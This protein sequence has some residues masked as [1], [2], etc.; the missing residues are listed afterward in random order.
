MPNLVGLTSQDQA[1]AALVDAS[2][3]LGKVTQVDS[4]QPAGAVIAQSVPAATLVDAGT[5]ID[6]SVSNGQVKV[7]DVTGESE[8]QARSDLTNAGF[9]P[10][11][12]KQ[13]D[14]SVSPGTVLAQSPKGGQGHPGDDHRRHRPADHPTPTPTPTWPRPPRRPDRRHP[15]RS[16]R[17]RDPAGPRR[18]VIDRGALLVRAEAVHERPR[19][20]PGQGRLLEADRRDGSSRRRGRGPRCARLR[21]GRRRRRASWRASGARPR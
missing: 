5:A 17:C 2:L 9:D 4:D 20:R 14:G 21:R 6:I 18:D 16:R 3:V 12:V 8:A 1:R 15:P 10:N 7:P 13:Q 11:V 19:R